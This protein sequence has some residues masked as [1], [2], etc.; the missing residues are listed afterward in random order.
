MM[1]FVE[2]EKNS[3]GDD[4]GQDLDIDARIGQFRNYRDEGS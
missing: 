4:D 3:D 2:N 1:M